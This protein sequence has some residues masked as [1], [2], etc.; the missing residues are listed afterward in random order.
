M[1]TRSDRIRSASSS[2]EESSHHDSMILPK[3]PMHLFSSKEKVNLGGPRNH[4][5]TTHM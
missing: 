5:E 1:R 3:N 2:V 4:V